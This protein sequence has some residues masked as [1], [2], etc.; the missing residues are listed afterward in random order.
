MSDSVSECYQETGRREK[1]LLI[2]T[3]KHSSLKFLS[4][5]PKWKRWE[6]E[7]RK[8]EMG[9]KGVRAICFWY[10]R[11]HEEAARSAGSPRH[12]AHFGTGKGGQARHR[13]AYVPVAVRGCSGRSS[14][15]CGCSSRLCISVGCISA[16]RERREL[17]LQLPLPR[18]AQ[19]NTHPPTRRQTD[20]GR[21]EHRHTHGKRMFQTASVYMLFLQCKSASPAQRRALLSNL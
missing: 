16:L 1:S 20:T 12:W 2:S 10:D 17:T 11:G 18:A 4:T 14:C 6:L 3:S 5:S 9:V 15:G 21:H 7:M 13:A 8:R 19:V